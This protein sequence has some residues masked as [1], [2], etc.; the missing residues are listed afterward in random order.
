MHLYLIKSIFIHSVLY[1]FESITILSQFMEIFHNHFN[2]KPDKSE[3]IK[4][5]IPLKFLKILNIRNKTITFVIFF[6]FILIFDVF[7]LLYDIIKWNSKIIGLI[8]INFY[9][10]SIIYF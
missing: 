9:T 10:F 7:Y 1:I 2:N 6:S 4:V 8:F 5:S 3:S